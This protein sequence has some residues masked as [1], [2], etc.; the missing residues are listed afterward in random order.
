VAGETPAQ[1]F[2]VYP[3]YTAPDRLDTLHVDSASAVGLELELF[4]DADSALR[5]RVAGIEPD[6]ASGCVSWP[7]ARLARPDGKALERRWIVGFP[8][9]RVIV[10]PYDSLPA[11]P[12]AD[13]TRLTIAVARAASKVEGDTAAAFRGRPFIVR[14][15]SRFRLDDGREAVLAEV[16]RVVTQ[17][18]NPLQEQLLLVLEADTAGGRAALAAVFAQRQ[19]GLEEALESVELTSVLRFRDG[20]WSLLLH[21]EFGEGSR[22]E[23]L[24]RAGQGRWTVRWR[25][26][27][28]GC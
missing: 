22:F 15:A 4:A 1:A 11:L 8:P 25:S 5:V 28:A 2:L 27:Y 16:A 10:A 14:Q 18:A 17:E 19:I 3:E 24:E 6:T 7:A 12:R 23:L 26:A 20:T 13:S 9:G 21:R